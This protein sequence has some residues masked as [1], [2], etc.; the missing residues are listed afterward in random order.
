MAAMLLLVTPVLIGLI[1]AALYLAGEV[2][3]PIVY[4]FPGGYRGW[5]GIRYGDPTC[6]PLRTEGWY[7]VIPVGSDGRGCTSSPVP[8]GWRYRRYE[9]IYPDGRRREL[10]GPDE[11]VLL[12]AATGP[13]RPN[14]G[15]LFVGSD[16]ELKQSW[17]RENE[18]VREMLKARDK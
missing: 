8:G 4:R 1:L 12:V 14:V 16:E 6:S 18:V 15:T 9:Y 3:Q 2:G 10:S 17:A 7:L 5:A 11:K 13:E